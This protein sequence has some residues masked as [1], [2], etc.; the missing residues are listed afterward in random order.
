MQR[1]ESKMNRHKHPW[2]A[3]L[4]AI[5]AMA[6]SATAVAQ[7]THGNKGHNMPTFSEFDLN[8]DGTISADEFNKARGARV[9]EH[10]AEGRQMKNLA[11]A[12]SFADI[13]TDADGTVSR[14]EFAA[15]QA[16]RMS[17]MG[18]GNRN[19]DRYEQQE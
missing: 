8:D 6:V 4:L 7:G 18:Q 16:E 5:A 12:P 19:Q 17:K 9:A 11:Y 1:G 15:H 13:D 10:A 2:P 3:A 14:E